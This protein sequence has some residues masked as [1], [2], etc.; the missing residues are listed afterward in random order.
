MSLLCWKPSCDS[1]WVHSADRLGGE[2]GGGDELALLLLLLLLSTGDAAAVPPLL[3][4]CA[5]IEAMQKT[6]KT[7]VDSTGREQQRSVRF[8]IATRASSAAARTATPMHL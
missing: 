7:I 6:R 5:V 3:P 1:L 8:A 4:S 2:E